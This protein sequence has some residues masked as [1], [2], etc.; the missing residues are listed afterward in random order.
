VKVLVRMKKTVKW[1]QQ[2]KPLGNC[3]QN[4]LLNESGQAVKVTVP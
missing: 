1:E 4:V 2:E 3:K